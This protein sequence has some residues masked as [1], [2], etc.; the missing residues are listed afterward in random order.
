MKESDD[1]EELAEPEAKVVAAADLDLQIE[2]KKGELEEEGEEDGEYKPSS[3]PL[4][5]S[6][7]VDESRITSEHFHVGDQMD[8]HFKHDM[9]QLP[10]NKLPAA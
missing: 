1:E 4:E 9:Q 6:S 8:P 3:E 7:L 2:E 5:Y 10:E